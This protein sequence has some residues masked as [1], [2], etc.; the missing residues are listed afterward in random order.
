MDSKKSYGI[1][2][3]EKEKE[4]QKERKKKNNVTLTLIDSNEYGTPLPVALNAP[5]QY[6]LPQAIRLSRPM[7]NIS[8]AKWIT[9]AGI[10]C[11]PHFL[12]AS[13]N[14]RTSAFPNAP[15]GELEKLEDG[16][17]QHHLPF[18]QLLHAGILLSH[19][20]VIA[21]A[22]RKGKENVPQAHALPVRVAKMVRPSEQKN[23]EQD[24]PP[25]NTT[26]INSE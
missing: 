19:L 20:T 12:M 4:N 10:R 25:T 24:R 13:Q 11:C 14:F 22:K 2:R 26:C 5:K 8:A 15:Q 6:M 21:P 17:S 9:N 3:D 7:A 1:A 18:P 16:L 23:G